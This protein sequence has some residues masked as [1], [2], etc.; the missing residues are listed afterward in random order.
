[1][2]K[3]KA[4]KAKV[5]RPKTGTANVRRPKARKGVAGGGEELVRLVQDVIEQGANTA[6]D[7][8]RAVL[9]LPVTMLEKLGLEDTAAEVK[10]VQDSTI[11]AIYELI[12]DI[13]RK[14]GVLAKDLLKQRKGSKQ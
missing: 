2:T 10:K 5:A 11:G 8:H 7:I 12:H 6:E 13:N 4:I 1:V 9:D 3:P 14:V